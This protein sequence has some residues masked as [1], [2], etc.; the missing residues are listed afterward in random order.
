MTGSGISNIIGSYDMGKY[1]RDSVTAVWT[2][3]TSSAEQLVSCDLNGDSRDD[4]IGIW[5]DGVWIRYTVSNTWKKISSYKPLWITTGKSIDADAI[6]SRI[7]STDPAVSQMDV[8]DLSSEG[9]EGNIETTI[10]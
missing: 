9:P 6:R 5:P 7:S 1:Y 3:I 8:F 4:L 10:P 2:K